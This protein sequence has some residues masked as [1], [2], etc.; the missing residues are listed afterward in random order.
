MNYVKLLA[1]LEAV[2][3]AGVSLTP[4]VEAS[5]LPALA[6]LWADL[7]TAEP[8]KLG[9]VVGANGVLLQELLAALE[10]LAQSP[11]VL[12]LIQALLAKLV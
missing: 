2:V 4:T 11:A 12:A 10:S 5:L 1:D 8:A 9:D 3:A 7:T 6:A